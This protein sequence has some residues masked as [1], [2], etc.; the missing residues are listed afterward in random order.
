MFMV[1]KKKKILLYI[2]LLILITSFFVYITHILQNDNVI[3]TSTVSENSTPHTE[4]EAVFV[5][6]NSTGLYDYE[7]ENKR[8]IIR[9]KTIELLNETI[10]N[11]NISNDSKLDAENKILKIAS[12]MEKE[13][14]CESLIYAKGLGNATVFISDTGVTVAISTKSIEENDIIKIK[15]IIFEQTENNNI[16]IVE[17]KQKL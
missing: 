14:N 6:D 16:K 1:V 5:N 10:K 8:E 11:E 17:V 13:V 9:S 2:V 15:D 3:Q 12:D 7:F 4:D